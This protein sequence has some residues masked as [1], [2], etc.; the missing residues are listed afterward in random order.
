MPV[1]SKAALD[2]LIGSN[3]PYIYHESSL[4]DIEGGTT[5]KEYLL[6]QGYTHDRLH[7]MGLCLYGDGHKRVRLFPMLARGMVMA[8][9]NVLLL[10]LIALKDI[11]FLDNHPLWERATTCSALF[12]SAF[13]TPTEE[14]PL[15]S[16]ERSEV[17]EFLLARCQMG[18]RN[19]YSAREALKNLSWWTDDFRKTQAHHM[20]DYATDTM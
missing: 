3:I 12:V 6:G 11:V 5:L 10:P 2:N 18:R 20:R 1:P 15:T 16:T 17:E 8:G 9:D 19:Y 7:S 14:S 4:D 13:C